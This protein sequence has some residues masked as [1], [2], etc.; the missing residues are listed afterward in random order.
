MLWPRTASASIPNA[1]ISLRS[2]W[3]AAMTAAN[4]HDVDHSSAGSTV[5]P[6]GGGKIAWLGRYPRF[7]WANTRSI[8]SNEARTAGKMNAEI[9]KHVDVL[10]AHARKQK[11]E[12]A[13]S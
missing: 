1:L 8:W 5:C 7:C 12:R 4:P 11:G 6:V 2:A 3:F 9:G 10:A 13:R